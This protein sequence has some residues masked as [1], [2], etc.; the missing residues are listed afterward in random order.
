MIKIIKV[1][2]KIFL[3]KIFFDENCPNIPH[4]Y[5]QSSSNL[6]IKMYLN[7]SQILNLFKSL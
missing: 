2:K 4:I 6:D 1:F 7:L 3:F 5:I